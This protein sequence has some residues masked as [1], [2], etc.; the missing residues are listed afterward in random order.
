LE[1]ISDSELDGYPDTRISAYIY[2]LYFCGAPIAWKTKA[3][4]NVPLS[5]TEE[6]DYAT[7]EITKEVILAKNIKA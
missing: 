6:D 3:G 5:S 7:S 2:I 1:G 4:K